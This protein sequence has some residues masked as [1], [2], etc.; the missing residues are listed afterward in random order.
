[1]S[2]KMPAVVLFEV[3]FCWVFVS[4][5]KKSESDRTS[6]SWCN[7]RL[8]ASI[9]RFHDRH[10]FSVGFSGTLK[11]NSAAKPVMELKILGFPKAVFSKRWKNFNFF[12]HR[13]IFV[14]C[15]KDSFDGK[16]NKRQWS[17]VFGR[18]HLQVP[19]QCWGRGRCDARNVY[20][21]YDDDGPMILKDISCKIGLSS[22]VGIVGAN[23]AGLIV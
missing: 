10:W 19:L 3:S 11:G 21:S 5:P 6:R 13:G 16:M 17:L 7:E 23:G 8:I 2:L 22:R 12:G 9:L 1:M 20:F 4:P 15:W 18:W 14:D